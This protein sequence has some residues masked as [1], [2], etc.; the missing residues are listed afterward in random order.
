MKIRIDCLLL[1]AMVSMPIWCFSQCE[2]LLVKYETSNWWWGAFGS[3]KHPGGPT[4][5]NAIFECAWSQVPPGEQLA[6]LREGLLQ[7]EQTRQAIDNV[8]AANGASGSCDQMMVKYD[9]SHWWWGAFGNC[10]HPGGLTDRNAIFECAWS[11]VP[12]SDKSD[13]LK[14]R[15]RSTEFTRQGIDEVAA[16]NGPP[17]NCDQLMRKYDGSNW[18][19]GTFGNCKRSGGSTDRSQILDCAWGQVPPPDN[20]TC[21]EQRLQHTEQ[22]RKAI[23]DVLASNEVVRSRSSFAHFNSC[24]NPASGC[25]ETCDLPNDGSVPDGYFETQIPQKLLD[26]TVEKF[27]D[28]PAHHIGANE[29][30]L[31]SELRAVARLADPIHCSIPLA[32]I[33]NG[34]GGEDNKAIGQAMADLSVTGRR[35][36][37]S[38]KQAHKNPDYCQ[39]ELPAMARNLPAACP[40]LSNLPSKGELVNG[41]R[42]ALIRAYEVA[43]FLRTGENLQINPDKSRER[44]RLGWIAVSGEDDP[45]HRPVNVPS[46]DFPQYDIDVV[47]ETPRAQPPNPLSVTV[48]TRYVIAQSRPPMLPAVAPVTW[49]LR[50]EPQPMID[51]NAEVLIF[52]HGMDSRAEEANDIIK[53]LFK[54]MSGSVKNLVVISVD[55]P[56]SGYATNLDY[57]QVSPLALIGIPKITLLPVPVPIPPELYTPVVPVFVAASLP[58]PPPVIPPLTPIPDFAATGQTPVLDF[59]ETFVVRFI[60][61]LDQKVP[62]KNNIK[63]VIGGSLGGNIS[64][65]L[66]R[67]PGVPWLP[68]TVVWSPASIWDSLGEGPGP[69]DPWNML[70]HLGPRDAWLKASNRDPKDPNDLGPKRVKLRQDFFGSWDKPIVPV[71]IP[72]AQSDTWTSD[73]WPCKKSAIAAARLDR[74]E[75]YDPKFLTWHWRLGAEQLLY[76]H[77]S[78]DATTHLPRYLSNYKPMLLACGTEDEVPFN[79]IC[80]A[81]QETAQRMIMT[82]GK[83]SFLENTGHSLDNERRDFFAKEIDEFLGLK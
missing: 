51:P 23:D 9:G 49:M 7:T 46:S 81:T 5:R 19:W 60:D 47:V 18:W 26:T 66:G 70:K 28:P 6:C 52:V 30:R 55:L 3:C 39:K 71:L 32:A 64:F 68:A 12:N 29:G 63:A 1:A 10:K 57:E 77:S 8:A 34:L 40:L 4:D 74:H 53:A 25:P 22:T 21:L 14:E 69:G 13:C 15:L 73:K 38:F 35:A 50:S 58:P 83:A 62:I 45:P 54:R 76:S 33:Y 79:N 42:K 36:F 72:K 24:A 31:R 67:R 48:S 61:A 2:P 65:R 75:T 17:N 16:R 44:Q 80:S 20:Q 37:A 41:C 27:N 43:N 82:P 78:L 56:S 11:Q 59:I